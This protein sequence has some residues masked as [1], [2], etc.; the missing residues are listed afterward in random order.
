MG[1]TYKML[2]D[3]TINWGNNY[4][5]QIDFIKQEFREFFSYLRKEYV[6]FKYVRFN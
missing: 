5:K 6:S 1:E 3:L 2:R 4:N